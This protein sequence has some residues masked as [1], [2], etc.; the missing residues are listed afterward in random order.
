MAISVNNPKGIYCC[1]GGSCPAGLVAGFC[2]NPEPLQFGCWPPGWLPP[3]FSQDFGLIFAK[4]MLSLFK[5][6]VNV[7]A[8]MAKAMI[9]NVILVFIINYIIDLI[10]ISIIRIDYS[11]LLHY[12]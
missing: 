6:A 1:P 4:A 3:A 8:T 11:I 10:N 5:T 2:V 9:E 7:D 12:L